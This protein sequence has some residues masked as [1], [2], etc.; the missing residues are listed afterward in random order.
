MLLQQFV[1][2]EEKLFFF[3]K[4]LRHKGVL[5]S[6][7]RNLFAENHLYTFTDF[8]GER[9]FSTETKL[10]DIEYRASPIIEK[11]IANARMWK[12]SQLTSVERDTFVLFFLQ[13]WTRL[14]SMRDRTALNQVK[15]ERD[16]QAYRDFKGMSATDQID[17]AEMGKFI[18]KEMWT[19]SIQ[20]P[21]EFMEDVVLPILRSMSLGVAVAQRGQSGFVIGSDPVLRIRREFDLDHPDIQLWLPLAHD[22][23][24]F[25]VHDNQEILGG[26]DDQDIQNFNRD[27]FEQSTIVASRSRELIESLA[28]WGQLNGSVLT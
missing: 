8:D 11:I 5:R 7:P 1:D 18:G 19:R 3:N 10:A 20:D 12:F 9:N 13:L 16:Q 15:S 2:Q 14:P 23:A 4:G 22:V 27:I 6:T 21:G 25:L 26:L 28:A 17:R 24:V